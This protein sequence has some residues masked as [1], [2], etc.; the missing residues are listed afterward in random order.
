MKID[1]M[2][3]EILQ[4]VMNVNSDVLLREIKLLLSKDKPMPLT[5]AQRDKL[6]MIE[7]DISEA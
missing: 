3:L 2:K 5:T 4:I 6:N 1:Q 7:K